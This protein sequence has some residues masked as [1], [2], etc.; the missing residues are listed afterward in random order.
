MTGIR[1]NRI[2]PWDIKENHKLSEYDET[3]IRS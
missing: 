2:P 3:K 1:F